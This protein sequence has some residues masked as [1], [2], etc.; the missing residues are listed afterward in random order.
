LFLVSTIHVAEFNGSNK[1]TVY[2]VEEDIHS[3]AVDP[4][5]G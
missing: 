2:T 5:G 3:I 1:K 4:L